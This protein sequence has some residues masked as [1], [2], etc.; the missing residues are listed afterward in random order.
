MRV[1]VRPTP[2]VKVCLLAGISLAVAPCNHVRAG[3]KNSCQRSGTG[4]GQERTTF[5]CLLSALRKKPTLSVGGRKGSRRQ[6]GWNKLRE[7][8]PAPLGTVVR[9]ASSS[10]PSR[11]AAGN[12]THSE[13]APSDPSQGLFDRAGD[14]HETSTGGSEALLPR[15]HWPDQ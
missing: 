13:C 8:A 7:H 10:V 3:R 5:C 14:G 2:S 11:S 1:S 4:I 6:V 15:L 9:A 12:L